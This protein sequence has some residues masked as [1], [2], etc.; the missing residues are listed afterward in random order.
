MI[1]YK[2]LQLPAYGNR[3]EDVEKYI[4]KSLGDLQ[5]KYIDMYLIHIPFGLLKDGKSQYSE[6]KIDNNTDHVAI[7]KVNV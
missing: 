6:M 3:A 2:C 4:K 7:W 5:L 1:T